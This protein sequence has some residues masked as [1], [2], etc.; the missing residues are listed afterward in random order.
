MKKLKY[1]SLFLLMAVLIGSCRK[2]PQF[3]D[4][5]LDATKDVRDTVRRDTIDTYPLSMH[6]KAPNGVA[7]IQ[8]LDGTSY[9]PIASF[10]NEYRGQK[11][12][13][14]IY[15][16]DLKSI[17]RDTTLHFIVKVIDQN[18]RSY[19][20]GFSLTVLDFSKPIITVGGISGDGRISL[21]N[22]Y[23]MFKARFATGMNTVKSYTLSLDGAVFDTH[24]Y[25]L[26]ASVVVHKKGYVLEEMTVKNK[27]YTLRVELE[28]SKGTKAYKDI[29]LR[30]VDLDK[31]YRVKMNSYTS[32]SPQL[33]RE[34]N[35]VYNSLNP[36]RLDAIDGV[37]HYYNIN[38]V[39]T[40]KENFRYDFKYNNFGK[41]YEFSMTWKNPGAARTNFKY[42]LTY[43]AQGKLLSWAGGQLN[44]EKSWTVTDW[45]DG[46][47]LLGFQRET[48]VNK[49]LW[50]Y[51]DGLFAEYDLSAS[52]ESNRVKAAGVTTWAIP[53]FLEG[54]PPIEFY[55]PAFNSD[56]LEL[57]M[58]KN[59]FE[60]L[61]KGTTETSIYVYTS[62]EKGRLQSMRRRTS[63]T[64]PAGRE[65]IFEYRN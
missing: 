13:T 32:N 40:S 46:D 61:V 30:M 64:A 8:V 50:S 28:D 37:M 48:S 58:Y 59:G 62:D 41:V 42:A 9:E 53:T 47:R 52:S 33:T 51:E 6:I 45:I 60:R 55:N 19:N 36:D 63:V 39:L 18:L 35:F 44:Q 1:L 3:P 26:P 34:L 43:D 23:I 14:F 10:D 20:K 22:N 54:L 21:T 4:P 56:I 15:D 11:D 12:F 57:L 7:Q 25:D 65:Y 16:A 31:P 24:T 38:G 2:E 29:I 5:G 49:W 17:N 27:D